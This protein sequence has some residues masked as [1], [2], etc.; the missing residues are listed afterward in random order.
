MSSNWKAQARYRV[1]SRRVS[2]LEREGL[3]AQHQ[4]IQYRLARS[5]DDFFE[6]FQLLQRRF[7]SAGLT[8][9]SA[10]IRVEPFHLRDDCQIVLAMIGPK[11]VGCLTL[12]HGKNSL[13]L[14]LEHSHPSVFRR[15]PDK[16]TIGEVTSLAIDPE[17]RNSEVFVGLMQLTQL[18]ASSV[19]IEYAVGVAHPK[20]AKIYRRVMGFEIVGEEVPCTRVGGQPGVA[21][22]VK[23]DQNT[24]CQPRWHGRFDLSRGN[25]ADLRP[26]PMDL[27][28]R[29]FFQNFLCDQGTS[30]RAA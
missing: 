30:S 6:A 19:G 22:A 27:G 9:S 1:T 12:L 7:R 3:A 17:S 5:H 8:R 11:V 25:D 23:I 26:S 18:F 14:P 15:L 10:P 28:Q 16:R 29:R 2:V 20:H 21:L 4:L 13:G 24:V